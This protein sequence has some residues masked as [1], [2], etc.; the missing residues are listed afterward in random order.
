MGVR[1]M[2]E[3]V[4]EQHVV[5]RVP[6]LAPD[7]TAAF[8]REALDRAIRGVKPLA[9]AAEAADKALAGGKSHLLRVVGPG[10]ARFVTVGK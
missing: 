6:H 10:G 8:V 9:P 1:S 5:P 2:G 7:L 3:K 4:V